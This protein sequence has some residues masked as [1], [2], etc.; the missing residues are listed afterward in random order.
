[1]T[2]LALAAFA[3]LFAIASVIVWRRPG[4]ALPIFVV[5]LALHNAVMDALYGAGVRGHVLTVIQGWKDGLLVVA[6]ARVA[7]DAARARA[8]PFRPRLPDTFALAFGALVVLYAL[9]PQHWLGGEAT[10]KGVAYA[11]RHD[12]IGVAA[13]FLGRAVAPPFLLRLRWLIVGVAAGVAACGLVDVYAISLDWWRHNGTIGYFRNQLDFHYT[14][15]LSGLPENFVYNTG[16]EHDVLRR[17]VS[18][19]LSPLGSAYVCGVSLL[20]APRTRI[21]LPLAVLAA[22]GVL[23]A[24]TRAALIGLAVAL[25]V[26]AFAWRRLWPLVAAAAVIAIGFAF[27]KVFPHIGPKTSFTRQELAYQHAHASAKASG[28]ATSTREPSTRQ[29]L[30]SLREGARTVIHH[31]QGYGLGN[32]GEIAF[33][34]G[35]RLKAGES[36]YTEIGVETGLAGA[37]LF[38]AWNLSLLVAL[39]RARRA[40]VAAALAFVLVVAIQT[41]AYGIPWLAYCVWW[42]AGS[43]LGSDAWRSTPASTSATST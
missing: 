7:L 9:I 14:P 15:A 33:R 41:D 8:L 4:V 27:I 1:M 35:T 10:T 25:V 34:T 12:I 24:Y 36:N 17:L 31:P 16:N 22:A 5:G 28:S 40:E 26:T 13:Y 37:L 32:A 21:T 11:F 6:L 3:L 39:V 19:F 23:W 38:I 2:A 43:A 42:I 18:T 20:L 29:H 30:K